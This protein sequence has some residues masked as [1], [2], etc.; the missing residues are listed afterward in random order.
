MA[1][2]GE[3]PVDRVSKQKCSILHHLDLVSPIDYSDSILWATYPNLAA[4][5]V[6][7]P[8]AVYYHRLQT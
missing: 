3:F 5:P 4:A 6:A 8:A 7:K 1:F 2:P